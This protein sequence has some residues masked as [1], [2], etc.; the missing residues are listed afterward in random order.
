MLCVLLSSDIHPNGSV[1]MLGGPKQV[2]LDASGDGW[3]ERSPL[4]VFPPS[5]SYPGYK[6]FVIYL[7][8]K[9]YICILLIKVCVESTSFNGNYSILYLPCKGEIAI[10]L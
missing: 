8:F 6:L 3:V 10:T 7:W 4:G 9:F 2:I 5:T 1:N